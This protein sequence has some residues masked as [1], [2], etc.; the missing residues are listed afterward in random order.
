M[1]EDRNSFYSSMTIGK[2]NRNKYPSSHIENLSSTSV[3]LEY[4]TIIS[5]NSLI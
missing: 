3:K 1:L 4:L 2:K 5:I